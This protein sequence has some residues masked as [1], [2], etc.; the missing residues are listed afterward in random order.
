MKGLLLL[1]MIY[2][3]TLADVSLKTK[4]GPIRGLATHVLDKP[5]YRFLGVPYAQ[6][7]VD[8]LR[9]QSP[10]P[11]VEWKEEIIATRFKP[12]CPQIIGKDPYSHRVD[13]MSDEG[14][15]SEDCLYLN[16]YTPQIDSDRKLP[17]F[18]FIHEGALEFSS[19]ANW[20]GQVLSQ[21]QQIVVVTFN[22]RL[23]VFGFLS[24][25]DE[26]NHEVVVE[27]NLGLLDQLAALRW[28][29]NHIQEYGGDPNQVTLGGNSAGAMTV[30]HHILMRKYH[31]DVR[32]Y[33]S[34]SIL[35]SGTPLTLGGA[36]IDLTRSTQLF[37]F[38]LAQLSCP[39]DTKA[40]ILACL[41]SKSTHDIM[42]AQHT[43]LQNNFLPFNVINH[44]NMYET[45]TKSTLRAGGF[46]LD[47]IMIGTVSDEGQYYLPEIDQ[48]VRHG[49][50]SHN[51]Y[52]KTIDVVFNQRS[53]A[54]R[55]AIQFMYKDHYNPSD[56]TRNLDNLLA[57]LSDTYAIA[58]AVYTADQFVQDGTITYQYHFDFRTQ[59]SGYFPSR[60]GVA[61][62]MELSYVFGYPLEKPSYIRDRYSPQDAIISRLMMD[63]WGNFIKTG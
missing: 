23:G 9:F 59:N 35:M 16:I 31:Q 52:L 55:E 57:C 60:L 43:L 63:L 30:G 4:L 41:M 53:N 33:F 36:H 45:D 17:V 1:S 27:P 40:T 24:G 51:V 2:G 54:V 10:K 50:I 48:F 32:P 25:F 38:M 34:R 28:I 56:N 44:V 61:K 18:V 20:Q 42:A 12:C 46:Q 13:P 21:H 15:Q 8:N 47:A 11:I 58:P 14:Q 7:P 39:N 5:H 6:A 29:H 49:G 3:Y 37:N 26:D 22:F 62:T 19:G